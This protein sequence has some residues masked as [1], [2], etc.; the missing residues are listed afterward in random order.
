MLAWAY[1]KPSLRMK[2]LHVLK[3]VHDQPS[4]RRQEILQRDRRLPNLVPH[5]ERHRTIERPREP[6]P[7][8]VVDGPTRAIDGIE[9][10]GVAELRAEG[11]LEGEEDVVAGGAD[12]LGGASG[13]GAGDAGGLA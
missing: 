5:R 1:L 13:E 10:L 3:A 12:A 11:R 2:A 4:R 6:S 9:P 7:P 8:P